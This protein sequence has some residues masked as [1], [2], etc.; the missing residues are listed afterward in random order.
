[1]VYRYLRA[2]TAAFWVGVFC[3]GCAS[4]RVTDPARTATEQFLTSE[5]V[6]RAAEQ[7]SFDPLRGRRVFIDDSY[8][9]D[10]AKQFTVG[11]FRSRLLQAGAYV[12]PERDRAEMV[13]EVRAGGIGIDRYESLV[14]IPSIAA[15][16]A[17]TADVPGGQTVLT[18]ELAIT[19]NIRQ[20]GYASLSYVAYWADSGEIVTT[21]GP[22]IG[23][24]LRQD[25]WIM[26]WGPRTVGNVPVVDRKID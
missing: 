1:M 14:G 13:V 22:Y 20:V 15:P 26:G 24:T 5:A 8:L 11:E 18:P 2:I 4:I 10:A 17:A 3:G 16:A 19:K 25:R 21:S 23:R 12:Q 6:I 9:S 7:L